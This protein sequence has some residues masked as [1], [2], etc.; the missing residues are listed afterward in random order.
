MT[1][2]KK[3]K[4]QRARGGTSRLMD[5]TCAKCGKLVFS[6]QKDGIGWLKRCY[7]NRIIT[8]EKWSTLQNNPAIKE[9]N[10]MPNLVCECGNLIGIP[11]RHKDGRLAYR[12]EIGS[13][14][15][16]RNG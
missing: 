7:L 11:M 13:F 3:D 12:L 9:P 1:K 8:P 4:Y 15:R 2:V 14:R 10:D 5:I 16:R 6:Y